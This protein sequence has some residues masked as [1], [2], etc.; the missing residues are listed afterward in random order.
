MTTPT[1]QTTPGN[2]RPPVVA[3]VPDLDRE[4]RLFEAR[5]RTA[6]HRVTGSAGDTLHWNG[7]GTCAPAVGEGRVRARSTSLARQPGNLAW[8]LANGPFENDVPVR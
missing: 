1:L 8:N 6:R 3:R 5:R 4:S 2:Y 7:A